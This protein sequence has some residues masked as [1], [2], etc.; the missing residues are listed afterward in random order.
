MF[1]VVLSLCSF[2]PAIA[3]ANTVLQTDDANYYLGEDGDSLVALYQNTGETRSEPYGSGYGLYEAEPQDLFV[4]IPEGYYS[5][6]LLGLYVKPCNSDAWENIENTKFALNYFYEDL[7]EGESYSFDVVSYSYFVAN[8]P[9]TKFECVDGPISKRAV[10]EVT[11]GYVVKF[12]KQACT[13][14]AYVDRIAWAAEPGAYETGDVVTHNG[15]EYQC[16]VGGWCTIGTEIGYEPGNG[17]YWEQAWVKL[18][19]CN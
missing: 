15:A 4:D 10:G 3:F 14:P 6:E 11:F 12:S 7:I 16:L 8:G 17:L 5:A 13:S 19:D 9:W 1:R 18:R 2:L